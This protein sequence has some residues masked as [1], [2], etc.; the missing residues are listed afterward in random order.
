MQKIIKWSLWITG[1]YAP[2][3]K[4]AEPHG[5]ADDALRQFRNITITNQTKTP[6]MKKNLSRKKLM[7]LV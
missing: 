5:I 1:E 4:D 6:Q 7:S 2:I 3:C